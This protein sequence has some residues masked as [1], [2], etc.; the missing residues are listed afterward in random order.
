VRGYLQLA[1]QFLIMDLSE[2]KDLIK[3]SLH[4]CELKLEQEPEI[5]LSE[6]DFER[7][8]CWSIMNRLGHND[9]RMPKPGDFTVHTQVSHYMDNENRPD[10]RVD[11]LLLTKEGMNDAKENRL[12]GYKYMA[13][14]FAIELKYFHAKDPVSKIK[15]IKCDFC[16]RDD[17]DMNSWLYVVALVE[18][19]NE[20]DYLEKKT[21]IDNLK[22][23]MVNKNHD[24]ESNLFHYVMNKKKVEWKQFN[25]QED[26]TSI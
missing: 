13:D 12:K 4:D 9:Y 22:D 8:V 18:S 11:I 19:E 2:L 17:L 20:N 15:K 14:S 6:A 3:G 7:L 26:K 5:V 21:I 24:Y 10:Y 23:E 25:N 1:N 16:K